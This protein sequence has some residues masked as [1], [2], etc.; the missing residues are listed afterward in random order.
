MPAEGMEVEKVENRAEA[1][2]VDDI[3]DRATNGQS[4][5]ASQ[6]SGIGSRQPNREHGGD[7]ERK[8]AEQP[9]P[10]RRVRL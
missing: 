1:Q 6:Q 3:A 9:R 4:K 8:S 7:D 10:N 5:R 2:P